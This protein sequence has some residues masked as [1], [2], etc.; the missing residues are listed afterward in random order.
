VCVGCGGLVAAASPQFAR[1]CLLTC[2]APTP[3]NQPLLNVD[4]FVRPAPALRPCPR[5]KAHTPL[6]PPAMA[7]SE[8]AS[9]MHTESKSEDAPLASAGSGAAA[10]AAAAA[11]AHAKRHRGEA[12][13]AES[14]SPS[15]GP[16]EGC[17]YG[18]APAQQ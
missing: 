8:R 16:G 18:R 11:A 3:T 12:V 2:P 14:L 10:A 17:V 6:R 7:T 13:F 5:H 15:R 4:L 1:V 9:I